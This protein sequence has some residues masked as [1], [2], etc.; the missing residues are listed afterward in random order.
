MKHD[1]SEWLEKKRKKFSA[2]QWKIS[3]LP[4][5]EDARRLFRQKS[6]IQ[7]S[8]PP[9][10]SQ[11]EEKSRLVGA[12]MASTGTAEPNSWWKEP[13]QNCSCDRVRGETSPFS[14]AM[15]VTAAAIV[16]GWNLNMKSSDMSHPVSYS[17]L[18]VDSW[19]STR[20]RPPIQPQLFSSI[21]LLCFMQTTTLSIF[22]SCVFSLFYIPISW[23][24]STLS[25]CP[26]LLISPSADSVLFNIWWDFVHKSTSS[27]PF[28]CTWMIV[29]IFQNLVSVNMPLL[30]SCSWLGT[31]L[32]Q[33]VA[34]II[35]PCKT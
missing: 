21:W 26:S 7:S 11:E 29:L 25:L 18:T 4:G 28:C 16:R 15:C 2:A 1:S 34:H 8:P 17:H 23:L 30:V 5:T 31:F 22:V 35:R 12:M 20:P 3:F 24:L 13:S 10:L 27:G 33:Y 32:A 19:F 14:T 6:E 9:V